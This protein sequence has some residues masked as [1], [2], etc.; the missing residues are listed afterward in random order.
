MRRTHIAGVLA[1]VLLTAG[2]VALAQTPLPA[3]KQQV[4]QNPVARI[5]RAS[6]RG[7]A[8]TDSER[9]NLARVSSVYTPKFKVLATSAKPAKVAL[10]LARQANDT[11]SVRTARLQLRAIRQ[12]GFVLLR[13]TMTDVR[14]ALAPEH[15]QRFNRNAVQIR[16]AMQK[17]FVP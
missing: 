6:L 3:A 5:V 14:M 1:A 13:S 9:T 4:Q 17:R 16:R 15:R 8:L 11:A 10:R 7:I 2:T 12:D